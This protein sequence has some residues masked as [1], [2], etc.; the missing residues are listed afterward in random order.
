MA[1]ASATGIGSA[2]A[3][4][5]GTSTGGAGGGTGFTVFTSRGGGRAGAAGRAG[6]G[7]F[8]APFFAGR[9]G[10][11]CAASLNISEARGSVIF[12]SRASFCTNSRATTS[13]IVLDALFTS[14]PERCF[15]SAITSWLEV[16]SS[17]A[18]L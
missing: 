2:G 6:S 14:M 1:G 11:W 5:G 7:G 16:L 4:A 13:S 10:A 18:T 15:S 8:A 12:R 9:A 17:S 3:A